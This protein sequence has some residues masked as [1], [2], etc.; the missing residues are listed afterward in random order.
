MMIGAVLDEAEAAATQTVAAAAGV[1]SFSGI[2][3]FAMVPD[4]RGQTEP[5][6]VR[7]T[8]SLAQETADGTGAVCA[9]RAGN[10]DDMNS[11]R[12]G[13]FS[14]RSFVLEEIDPVDGKGRW[15][16]SAVL[17]VNLG[18]P[19][20]VGAL[21]G[22]VFDVGVGSVAPSVCDVPLTRKTAAVQPFDP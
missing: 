5:M 3:G 12:V 14:R 15:S 6:V 8:A 10:P 9:V 20:P 19:N 7:V 11:Y 2:D 13:P 4:P 22:A 16:G 17:S 18:Q 1:P 21:Q